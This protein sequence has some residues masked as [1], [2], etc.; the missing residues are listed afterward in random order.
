MIKKIFQV[1]SLVIVIFIVLSLL[2]IGIIINYFYSKN[3]FIKEVIKTKDQTNNAQNNDLIQANTDNLDDYNKELIGSNENYDVFLVNIINQGQI[4]KS[5]EISI[6]DKKDKKT[7][8]IKGKFSI[9][10]STVVIDNEPNKLIVLSNGTY[11]SRGIII[12]SL[13]ERKQLVDQFCS[14]GNILFWKDYVIFGNCDTNLNRPRGVGE[15]PSIEIIDLLTSKKKILF[16]STDL[17][18]YYAI[19]ISGNELEYAKNYVINES[20]WGD[21]DKH[22]KETSIYDLSLVDI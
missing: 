18:E 19:S 14:S 8:P 12:I 7:V 15:A 5:G 6:Y 21:P 16:K 9:F 13:E 17:E 1:R 22:I 20:D 11:S 10:G 2:V 4:E 3:L